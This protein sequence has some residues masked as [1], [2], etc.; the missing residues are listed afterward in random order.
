MLQER[1]PTHLGIF[2]L[3]MQRLKNAC[4]RTERKSSEKGGYPFNIILYRTPKRMRNWGA[5]KA[6][7]YLGKFY[8][9][10]QKPECLTHAH[11]TR[12]F[13]FRK[14]VFCLCY[15]ETPVQLQGDENSPTKNALGVTMQSA[16]F[17]LFAPELFKKGNTPY[18]TG[19]TCV[20]TIV[21]SSGSVPTNLAVGK[22]TCKH[23]F[24][25]PLPS[26][27]HQ[28]WSGGIGG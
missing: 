10:E 17:L 27:D 12:N 26:L 2:L 16:G 11:I 24:D 8:I 23:V 4:A 28:T 21:E 3:S 15:P 19:F 14:L 18:L 25:S 9:S 22:Q 1:R 6:S 13:L 20:S 7:I 5:K